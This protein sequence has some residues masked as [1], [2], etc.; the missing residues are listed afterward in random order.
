MTDVG[1]YPLVNELPIL[2]DTRAWEWKPF[3]SPLSDSRNFFVGT[4]ELGNTW[5]AKMRGGFRGYR[6]IIFERLIQ[7]VGWAC[8][9]S[10][11]ASLDHSS[12]PSR[13]I[14]GAE[15]VQLVTRLLPEHGLDDCNSDCPI[16]PLRGDLW[17]LD[18]DP[19]MVLAGS[20][21]E[22]ALSVARKEILAPLLGGNEPAGCLTTVDH[23]VFLIDGELMFA[24]N[25]SDVRKTCWWTRPDGSPW[26][27]GQRLTHEICAAVGSLQDDELESFL[28]EPKELKIELSWP[29]RPLLYRARDCARAFA[30]W[31]G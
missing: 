19:I 30:G 9:S 27:A 26:P 14:T 24:G 17:L 1:P 3:D 31:S 8:Q 18:S 15:S 2:V 5:L 25:P 6:E 28:Q 13:M 20:P 4:D 7:R 10:S 29:I 22:G 12:L 23:R 11:F 16:G 21:L